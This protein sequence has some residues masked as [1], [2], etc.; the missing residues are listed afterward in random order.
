MRKEYRG[1]NLYLPRPAK[2]ARFRKMTG[3]GARRGVEGV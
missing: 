3:L 2:P 1:Q